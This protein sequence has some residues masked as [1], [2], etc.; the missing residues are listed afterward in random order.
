MNEDAGFRSK[1]LKVGERGC[2]K[3]QPQQG[4]VAGTG[5]LPLGN[6]TLHVG[7]PIGATIPITDGK[8]SI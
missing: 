5:A 2:I 7:Q 1:H 3:P 6:R 8:L 4:Q